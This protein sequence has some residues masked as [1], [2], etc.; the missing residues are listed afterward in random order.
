[1]TRMRAG[2]V[3]VVRRRR[4]TRDAAPC[5]PRRTGG[6]SRCAA[7]RSS[8][9]A[10]GNAAAFRRIRRLQ[11][12]DEVPLVRAVRSSLQRLHADAARSI[13]GGH[14]ADANQTGRRRVAKLAR[15]LERQV[16]TERVARRWRPR[17]PRR[18][19]AARASRPARRASAPSDRGRATAASVPPQLRWLRRTTSQPAAHA[20]SEMPRM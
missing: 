12:A 2:P 6:R 9:K 4:E 5:R 17:A 20:L 3:V 13:V 16:S 14:G 15:Q 10:P 8:E 19:R 18:A 11:I 1:M 7:A